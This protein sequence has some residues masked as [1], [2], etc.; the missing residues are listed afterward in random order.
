MGDTG[1][2]DELR[3]LRARVA[4]LEE[5]AAVQGDAEEALK[6]ERDFGS[7][8]LETAGVLVVVLD[9]EGRIV[10]FNR[11]CEQM[12]GY[13][14][15][16]VKGRPFWDLFLVPEELESVAAVFRALVAGQYPSEHENYWKTRDGHRRL[17][18]WSNTVLVDGAGS[19]EYLVATG[20]DITERRRVEEELRKLSRAVEQSPSSTVITDL[21]GTIEYVN[22]KFTEITGYTMPEVLGRNPRL[23]SSDYLPVEFF[24]DLWQTIKAGKEWRGEFCNR[25]KSGEVYWESA[26]ISPI[27]GARG[28]MTHFLKLGEDVT[29]RKRAEDALAWELGVNTAI[30]ELSR[31]LLSPVSLDEISV[32]VLAFGQRL[33]G[34]RLGFVGY[35]DPESGYLI[36][37]IMTHGLGESSPDGARE[38]VFERFQGLL[39]K[40]LDHRR[41]LLS[42]EAGLADQAGGLSPGHLPI[43]RFLAAP[44]LIGD[45]LVGQLAVANAEH[46]YTER[47]LALME[48]LA[49][50]YAT[51]LQ[52]RWAEEMLVQ[53]TAELESRNE[54]LDTFAHMVA[55]D[56][57]DPLNLV[58]GFA[59]LLVQAEADLTSEERH[60]YLETIADKG[61]KMSNIIEALLLLAGVRKA[62]VPLEPLD[63]GQIVAE[64]LARLADMIEQY[65][66]E[67]Q[68]PGD[69]P[70]ALGYGPWVEE[71]WVNYVSNAI[72]YGGRPPVIALGA[73]LL[74]AGANEPGVRYWVRD[75]GRGLSREEQ[76][77]LFKP[78]T[79]LD[80]M[81]V[82]GHGL[83]LSIVRRIVEKLGG[84]IG[85][86]SDGVPGEG[87]VFSFTLLANKI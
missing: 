33:T 10:R 66:A 34:S 1:R 57:Q 3:A 29:E 36:C 11:A 62:Q 46:D 25:K 85:V 56:L 65:Q 74:P 40:V 55:H 28:T 70:M 67:I 42:N 50:L 37:P 13:S 2:A 73:E 22:P 80:P 72:K 18:S 69:W 39:G 4:E 41:A 47:D 52:R 63:M 23:L 35:I 54:E 60:R 48:R 8:V 84:R 27:R 31:S 76:G 78:F 24:K 12:T 53:R 59:E 5:L 19:V 30:S 58:I 44:A 20:I 81:H 87:S 61:R 51:A 82:E 6:R 32:L 21:E 68:C 86:E 9:R 83:G 14:F 15:A 26:S 16:E 38:M 49:D 43:D 45:Q 64:A 79:Q 7:A 77:D 71:V 17:V 75:N